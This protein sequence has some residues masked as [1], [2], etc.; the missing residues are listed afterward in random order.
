MSNI[1]AS[2][3]PFLHVISRITFPH[4]LL[5]AVFTP[6]QYTYGDTSSNM[7]FKTRPRNELYKIPSLKEDGI[8]HVYFGQ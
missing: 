3:I 2:Y 6:T 8:P 4:T 7:V 1:A 5:A